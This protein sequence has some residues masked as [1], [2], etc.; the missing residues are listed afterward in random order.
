MRGFTVP[1]T[2]LR[3]PRG[4]P[5]IDQNR[6]QPMESRGS[7]VFWLGAQGAQPTP[8]ASVLSHC[9]VRAEHGCASPELHTGRLLHCLP[10][11]AVMRATS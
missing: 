4:L 5:I 8:S 6:R 7:S 3:L 10:A 1:V 2:H 11:C 9:E